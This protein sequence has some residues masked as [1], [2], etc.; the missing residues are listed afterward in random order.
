MGYGNWLH[1]EAV[2]AGMTMA[3]DLSARHGWLSGADI[4]R[5]RTLLI[6]A[7]LPVAAPREMSRERFL[8][9]MAV[10]KKTLDGGLRLVLMEGIGRS[11]VCSD[12]DPRLLEQTLD[13]ELPLT[14]S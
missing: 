12:F 13:P 4:E 11:K 3:A 9:L 14:G 1:G 2:A 7:K 8:D 10:D 5:I 6:R